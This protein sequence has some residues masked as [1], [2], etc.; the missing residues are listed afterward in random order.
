MWK[1]GLGPNADPVVFAEEAIPIHAQTAI[2]RD[3]V[4]IQIDGGE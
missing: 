1:L 2:T 3:N 4:A